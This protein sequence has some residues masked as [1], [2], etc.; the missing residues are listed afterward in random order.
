M[1]A[2]ESCPAARGCAGRG[3]VECAKTIY[4]RVSESERLVATLT[5][6]IAT[7]IHYIS[8]PLRPRVT[9]IPA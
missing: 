7:E 3:L 4:A 5:D 2:I 8:P 1:K 9:S 6:I